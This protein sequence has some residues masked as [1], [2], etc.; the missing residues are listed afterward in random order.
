MRITES[1]VRGIVR[2]TIIEGLA[3]PPEAWV[4]LIMRAHER[5]AYPSDDD[6][7][8]QMMDDFY[9]GNRLPYETT[10]ML[11][12]AVPGMPPGL[13]SNTSAASIELP[14]RVYREPILTKSSG[15]KTIGEVFEYAGQTMMALS[16]NDMKYLKPTI[17]HELIHVMQNLGKIITSISARQHRL[18]QSDKLASGEFVEEK[19]FP[20]TPTQINYGRRKETEDVGHRSHPASETEFEAWTTGF[21]DVVEAMLPDLEAHADR[22]G[23]DLWDVTRDY[24]NRMMNQ[25]FD[26]LERSG[27]DPMSDRT[28]LDMTKKVMN[29]VYRVVQEYLDKI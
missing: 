29:N 22:Q 11:P 8:Y 25:Q 5:A 28:R 2:S 19:D 13:T 12:L 14:L 16:T 3:R 17:R 18:S 10:V 7:P 4:D 6:D 21:V 15:E 26:M 27:Y 23:K 1:A 9:M 24:A 20:Q